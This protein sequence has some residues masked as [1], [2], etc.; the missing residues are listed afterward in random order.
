MESKLANALPILASAYGQQFGVTVRIGGDG[1]WTNGS[2]IQIPLIQDPELKDVVLGYLVH[3]AAHVRL[4]N[5]RVFGNTSGILRNLV[6]ILEDV[7]IER[8]MYEGDYPGTKRTL[9]AVWEFGCLKN[10]PEEVAQAANLASLFS[11]Y[12]LTRVRQEQFGLEITRPHLESIQ[13][14]LE[15]ELPAGFFVRL[16]VL[17]DQ[18]FDSMASTSDAVH[19]AQAMLDA[20]K[21]A[22]EE[23]N[24][25]KSQQEQ[26]SNEG[27]SESDSD[28]DSGNSDGSDGDSQ[29]NSSDGAGNSDG[30][31]DDAQADSDGNGSG[32]SG[33]E[34]GDSDGNTGSGG[35]SDSDTDS[36]EADAE[37]NAPN[38]GGADCDGETD[39]SSGQ[40]PQSGDSSETSD[41]NGAGG[42]EKSLSEQILSES[43]LP[44]DMMDNIRRALGEQATE[45]QQSDPT[46]GTR[47]VDLDSRLGDEVSVE[48]HQRQLDGS[49]TLKDGVLGSA[50]L[51]AQMVGLLQAQ[52]RSRT[53]HRE[54]GKRFD[55]KRLARA[56]A[57]ERQIWK[58]KE[59]KSMVDTSVHILLDTSG[60]MGEDQRIANSATVS[61]ALAI[62]AIPKADV[63]VSIF[64]GFNAAVSPLIKR[65]AA[66]RPNIPRFAVRAGGGTPMAEAMFYAARELSVVS[67]R[68]RKVMIVITDGAPNDGASVN[69]INQLVESE[70]DVYAIGIRA[71]AV[72]HYFKNYQVISEVGQLQSALFGLAKEFLNVA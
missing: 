3:E 57:G 39:S 32:D 71:E 17:L 13:S 40:Q 65:K 34:E 67:G 25:E 20:L 14:A 12:L 50:K 38:Q 63:A 52:S 53:S 24:Q 4:T 48:D 70:I 21:Q 72:R 47:N 6:N 30:S 35:S 68:N 66:V 15:K 9:S 64:P 55:T 1:A 42:G 11:N 5:F 2:T 49:D 43:D 36:G 33:S 26:Q 60:S 27:S 16:D 54:Y 62:S 46:G 41:G 69:Y 22:E 19:L 51:R 44:G 45:E 18:H 58:H 37:S 56:M 29:E 23:A 28:T 31:D 10:T 61:L 8:G 59:E 7:R